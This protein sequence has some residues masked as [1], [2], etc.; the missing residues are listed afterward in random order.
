MSVTRE[1]VEYA[2]LNE[3]SRGQKDE[4]SHRQRKRRSWKLGKPPAYLFEGSIKGEGNLELGDDPLSNLLKAAPN[5][6]LIDDETGERQWRKN[7][8]KHLS[9]LGRE[10]KARKISMRLAK[11]GTKLLDKVARKQIAKAEGVTERTLRNW[12]KGL[13]KPET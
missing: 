7:Q 12:A 6:V 5:M 1:L 3:I 8:G 9:K 10:A 11:Y 2:R 13:E 4:A